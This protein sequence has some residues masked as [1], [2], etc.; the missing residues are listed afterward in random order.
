MPLCTYIYERSNVRKYFIIKDKEMRDLRDKIW[1][2][3]GSTF[4]IREYT[5]VKKRFLRK[6]VTTTNYSLLAHI[7]LSEYQILNFATGNDDDS[8]YIVDKA[9]IINYFNGMLGGLKRGNKLLQ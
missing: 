3:S 8:S 4:F 6:D 2:K 7:H 5:R 9:H 1:H